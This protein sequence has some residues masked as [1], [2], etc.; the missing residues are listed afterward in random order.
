MLVL[1]AQFGLGL[2]LLSPC[3]IVVAVRC[4]GRWFRARAPC[5]QTLPQLPWWWTPQQKMAYAQRH[6][7]ALMQQ[8]RRQQQEQQQTSPREQDAAPSA[9]RSG[10]TCVSGGGS[11]GHLAPHP[12]H[13]HMAVGQSS[14]SSFPPESPRIGVCGLKYPACFQRISLSGPA[15]NAKFNDS[16]LCSSAKLHA[17]SMT[18]AWRIGGSPD[19]A[20]V[21]H[22]TERPA[23]RIS[24]VVPHRACSSSAKNDCFA[25]A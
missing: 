6:Q 16:I 24:A 13:L 10:W 14:E 3:H 12:C 7:M 2:S 22:T 25:L 18:S 11:A 20:P 19:L 23:R 21:P 1:S 4:F 17:G 5:G 8:Q 9:S 15:R